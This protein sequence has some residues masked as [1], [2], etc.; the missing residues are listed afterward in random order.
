[1]NSRE[2]VK[3]ALALNEGGVNLADNHPSGRPG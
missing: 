3:E 1:M 2:I